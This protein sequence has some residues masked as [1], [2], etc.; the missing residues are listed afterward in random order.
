[1]TTESRPA[2][3]R[4]SPGGSKSLPDD[5]YMSQW[6]ERLLRKHRTVDANGCWNYGGYLTRSGYGEIPFRG[7]NYRVHRLFYALFHGVEIDRW[8]YVCHHCDNKKCFRPSHLFL[9]TPQ[10]NSLDYAKKGYHHNTVKTHC[11][12]GHEYDEENTYYT[13]YGTRSCRK[14][15][16][17]RQRRE[18]HDPTKNR[19]AVQRAYRQRKRA[20]RVGVAK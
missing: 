14:C 6:L 2:K 13:S 19:K 15:V 12:R 8:L 9:G 3:T 16:A 7:K 5:V 1:M 18:Y 20:E 11:K 4:S 17:A 10:D